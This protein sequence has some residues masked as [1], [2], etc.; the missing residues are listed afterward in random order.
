MRIA[1][2]ETQT[3]FSRFY[4]GIGDR[5]VR[6]FSKV[7]KLKFEIASVFQLSIKVTQDFVHIFTLNIT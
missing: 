5:T 7:A 1:T 2:F 3:F 6:A 4:R